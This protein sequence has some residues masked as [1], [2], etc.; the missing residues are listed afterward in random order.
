MT[1]RFREGL[2]KGIVREEW[3]P[4]KRSVTHENWC[5]LKRGVTHEEG[6]LREIKVKGAVL[7]SRC[8]HEEGA[9]EGSIL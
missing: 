6:R 5:P 4:L 3:C 9:I 8:P 2:V 7:V 1:V